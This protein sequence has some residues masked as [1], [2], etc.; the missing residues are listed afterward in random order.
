MTLYG[1]KTSLKPGLVLGRYKDALCHSQYP[2]VD[3][4][5]NYVL[6]C[7]DPDAPE[8]PRLHWFRR[9]NKDLVKYKGPAPT[10]GKHRYIFVLFKGFKGFKKP[11][12]LKRNKWNAKQFIHDNKYLLKPVKINFFYCYS[13]K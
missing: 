6:I 2:Y 5:S 11:T 7:L 13:D 4:P 9:G 8:S 1:Y 10:L 3:V 12:S